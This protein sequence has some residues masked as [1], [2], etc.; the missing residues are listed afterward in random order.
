MTI[1]LLLYC[2][3]V[4]HRLMTRCCTRS[5]VVGITYHP[6]DVIELHVH[7][8]K[9]TARPGQVSILLTPVYLCIYLTI[10]RLILFRVDFV[11]KCFYCISSDESVLPDIPITGG[12]SYRI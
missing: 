10:W 8:E 6:G 2:C 4:I 9:F 7:K 5:H 1:P 3:D 12:V 11:F